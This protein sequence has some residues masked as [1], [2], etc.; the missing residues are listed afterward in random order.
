MSGVLFIYKLPKLPYNVR[1]KGMGDI[2]KV[3]MNYFSVCIW[4]ILLISI[5]A[6]LVSGYAYFINRRNSRGNP[7]GREFDL[8]AVFLAPVTWPLFLFVGMVFTIIKAVFFGV[9]LVLFSILMVV[10]RKPFFWPWI[11]PVISHVGRELLKANT[12]L[13]RLFKRDS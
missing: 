12:F 1:Q 13:I 9:F 6:W 7:G 5:L 10:I 2:F 11:E 4:G 8:L 3:D